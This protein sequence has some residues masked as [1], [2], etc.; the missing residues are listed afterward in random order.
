MLIF[1]LYLGETIIIFGLQ[2]LNLVSYFKTLLWLNQYLGFKGKYLK[3]NLALL[4]LFVCRLYFFS[5]L[6]LDHGIWSIDYVLSI[7]SSS[8][9]KWCNLSDENTEGKFLLP[10]LLE[11]ILLFWNFPWLKWANKNDF[12]FLCKIPFIKKSKITFKLTWQT[13][14]LFDGI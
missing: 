4:K 6:N 7:S 10:H 9:L 13:S 2:V 12:P 3:Y 5:V 11:N 14:V 8:W 1:K